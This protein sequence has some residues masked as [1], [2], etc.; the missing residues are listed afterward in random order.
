MR[1]YLV[2]VADGARARFFGLVPADFPPIES[3]PNLTELEDLVNPEMDAKGRDLW[4]NSKSGRGK[5]PG[6]GPAHGYDDHRES[7]REELERRFAQRTAGQIAEH[8][9]RHGADV[10]VIAAE[11]KMLGMLRAALE[12]RL[13]SG[14][15][16]IER[17]EDLSKLDPLQL[18]AHLAKE[19]ALPPRLPPQG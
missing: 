16:V 11:S 12:T 3:G 4:S 1:N 15:K 9:A 19:G 14:T 18:H 7:H 2:V 13:P 10:L 8:L 5:A 6:E 17:S